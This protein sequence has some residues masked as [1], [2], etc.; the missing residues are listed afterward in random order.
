MEKLLM[1]KLSIKDKSNNY[2]DNFKDI[3]KKTSQL[4]NLEKF[5]GS[6]IMI[7]RLYTQMSNA[8]GRSAKPGRKIGDLFYSE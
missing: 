3:Y 2:L 7:S 1:I 4:R 5:Y 8:F 6:L